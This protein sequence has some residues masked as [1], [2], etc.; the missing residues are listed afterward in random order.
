[1]EMRTA[2]NDMDKGKELKEK[3]ITIRNSQKRSNI[4]IIGALQ[5]KASS[6]SNETEQIFEII[7]QENFY[8]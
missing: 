7:I 1:M 3:I 2:K 5:K 4:H 6:S 8:A